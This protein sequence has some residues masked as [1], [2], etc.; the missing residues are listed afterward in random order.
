MQADA[1]REPG[2][3]AAARQEET[4]ERMEEA[5]RYNRWLLERCRPWLGRRVLDAGAGTGTFVELLAEDRELVVALEPDPELAGRLRERVAALPNV[6]VVAREAAALADDNVDSVVCFNVLEHIR[7]DAGALRALARALAPGGTL[8]LLV[9]AHPALFGSIDRAL[10]HERRYRRGDL[11]RLLADAGFEVERLRFVNPLGALGWLLWSRLGRAG[12]VPE[13]PL[14][15]YNRLV[16][17]LRALDAVELP[18]GLSL[19]AVARKTAE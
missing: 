16:P 8:L 19:W 6:R 10:G 11:R 1:Q 13:R 2:R 17:V 18:F 9:P 7:D 4:L 14:R 3:Y 12:G 15:L 5:R